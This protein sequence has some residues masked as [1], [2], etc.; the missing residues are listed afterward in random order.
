MQKFIL[1]LL[2][3][4][5]QESFLKCST[6]LVK[7]GVV[8]H[9]L[10]AMRKLILDLLLV[11]RKIISLEFISGVKYN[12][13]LDAEENDVFVRGKSHGGGVGKLLL[14]FHCFGKAKL[15]ALSK[16]I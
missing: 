4:F 6:Y 16:R 5:A 1:D 15:H 8:L 11:K 2:F 14:A 9:D 13:T 3:R 12:D 7:A 10:I